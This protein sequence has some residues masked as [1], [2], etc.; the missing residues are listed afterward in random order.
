MTEEAAA[1]VAGGRGRD[2]FD[3]AHKQ[4]TTFAH[5][6]NLPRTTARQIGVVRNGKLWVC[7]R[8]RFNAWSVASRGL[9][10]GGSMSWV[11]AHM[12]DYY[13]SRILSALKVVLPHALPKDLHANSGQAREKAAAGTRF[14][15]N[16]R[17]DLRAFMDWDTAVVA[18]GQ[19]QL[20]R[21]D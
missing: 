12:N 15:D 11:G 17:A 2:P 5:G 19:W 10:F 18:R 20:R 21:K 1:S 16:C 6:I 8:Q 14:Q 7:I 4:I 13:K 3:A 9:R